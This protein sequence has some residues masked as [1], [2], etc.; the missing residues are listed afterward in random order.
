M[1]ETPLHTEEDVLTA[2]DLEPSTT[3]ACAWC[4]QPL[5]M[6][7]G[8][9]RPREY[10][11]SACRQAAYL[12]RLGAGSG[13]RLAGAGG[14]LP[15][16]LSQPPDPSEGSVERLRRRRSH[17]K[18]LLKRCV[19]ESG[20]LPTPCVRV[21]VRTSQAIPR[22]AT[23]LYRMTYQY[24]VGPIPAGM[25]LDHLCQDGTCL[26]ADH[27]DPVTPGENARRTAERARL[28]A[29]AWLAA[30]GADDP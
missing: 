27:L 17:V 10:C 6:Y 9:G 12:S 22:L 30:R 7:V 20:P 19:I 18:T 8:I 1:P 24:W 15:T 11:D 26:A 21:P 29:A 4:E 23:T 14:E 3:K 13:T 28:G 16:G 2:Q 25:F 5:P